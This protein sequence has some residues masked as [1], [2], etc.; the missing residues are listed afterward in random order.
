MSEVW[1]EI[2]KYFI[3]RDERSNCHLSRSILK[4][5]NSLWC[6]IQYNA[7]AK[8]V[9]VTK[10]ADCCRKKISNTLVLV[11]QLHLAVAMC[12]SAVIQVA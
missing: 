6:Y 12:L 1:D 10:I 2:L 9:T 8:A 3:K 11:L 5:L 7:F 4:V